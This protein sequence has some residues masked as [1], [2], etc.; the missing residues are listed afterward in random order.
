MTPS[1]YR[2]ARLSDVRASISRKITRSLH[3][4]CADDVE[5]A[6]TAG[7]TGHDAGRA[8]LFSRDHELWRW[9]LSPL[10]VVCSCPWTVA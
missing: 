4:V 10:A 5:M 2:A 3:E 1:S 8:D 9:L 6:S 7:R